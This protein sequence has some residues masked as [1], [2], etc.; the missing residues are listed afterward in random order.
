MNL[1]RKLT[2]KSW[3]TPGLDD[4]AAQTS[5]PVQADAAVG[6]KLYFAVMAVLFLLIGTGFVMHAGGEGA[7]HLGHGPAVDGRPLPHTMLL[8]Y[9]SG[10]LILSSVALQLA[11][12]A[13]ARGDSQKLQAALLSGGTLAVIFLIGQF[14]VW[15]QFREGGYFGTT[16]PAV[17]FF[18]LIIG[19]HGLHLAGGL[20]V[21]GRALG[22]VMGGATVDDV[23]LGVSLCALYWH[24]L[25]LIWLVMFALLLAI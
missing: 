18:Y 1:F 16:N 13:A 12:S 23:R 22:R 7:A 21:W 4:W 24:V 5:G 6:L 14:A 15:Q 11:S 20:F 17:A 10:I 19:L 2:Q 8:W 3:L 9:N 25:L